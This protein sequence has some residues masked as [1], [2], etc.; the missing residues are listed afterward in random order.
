[1]NSAPIS[2]AAAAP[3]PTAPPSRSLP[4][5]KDC[6]S[7]EPFGAILE[8]A[9]ATADADT[10]NAAPGKPTEAKEK[11]KDDAPTDVP[12]VCF[13]PPPV[14]DVPTASAPPT[15]TNPVPV[16]VIPETTSPATQTIAPPANA[17][18]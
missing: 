17:E 14:I 4:S 18:P 8:D 3:L 11:K 10:D 15:A 7:S 5:E 16:I 13:C 2:D 6:K 12:L 1:M 9:T